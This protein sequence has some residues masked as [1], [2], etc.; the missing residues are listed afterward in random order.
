VGES[1]VTGPPAF[2]QAAFA[3]PKM[4]KDFPPM[5]S[6][7]PT[8]GR[9]PLNGFGGALRAG[10]E[11]AACSIRCCRNRLYIVV[12]SA[13][14]QLRNRTKLF[15]RGGVTQMNSIVARTK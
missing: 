5:R 10:G 15:Q 6:C 9:L 14:F 3:P 11:E 1:V 12:G 4:R 13:R 2:V 7:E 8:V